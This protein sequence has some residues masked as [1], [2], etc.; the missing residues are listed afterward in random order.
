[1]L[2][3]AWLIPLIPAISFLVILFFV[4]YWIVAGPGS[5]LFLAG[6]GQRQLSWAIFAV[7]GLGAT[8]LTVGVVKLVEPDIL[9]ALGRDEPHRHVDQPEADGTGPDGSGHRRSLVETTY[10]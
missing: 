2:R 6:K 9:R 7:A 8:L 5:Y 1:M 4:G 10:V 3:N